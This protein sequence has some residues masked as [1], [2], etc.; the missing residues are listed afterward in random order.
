MRDRRVL[1][2]H[3]LLCAERILEYTSG[4]R[5]AFLADN[6]TQDAVVRNLEVIGQIV[7]DLDAR[8]L[9]GISAGVPWHAIAG[10]RNVLA[11][12][13]LGV[14]MLLVWKVVED[15]VPALRDAVIDLLD[16]DSPDSASR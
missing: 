15:Y 8:R 14:D 11:H 16:G 5:S 7:R 9:G 10:M 3:M 12:Q 13:Y 1:L 6:R 2:S 4:G